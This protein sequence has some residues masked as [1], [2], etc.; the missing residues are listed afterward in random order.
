MSARS[1]AGAVAGVAALAL[2]AAALTLPGAVTADAGRPAGA[3]W[4]AN[5]ED[6]SLTV[7]DAATNEVAATLE[8]VAGPHNVQAGSGTTVWAVASHADTL[9]RLDAHYRLHGELPTGGH[10]AHVVEAPGGDV[11]VTNE[12]DG[13]VSVVDAAALR[14]VAT[15]TVGRAPH[16]LRPSPDGRLVLVANSGSG[17][18]TAIDVRSRRA[19]FELEVG[20]EP[21]QVAFAPGGRTAYVT[22]RGE[23]AVAKI[24]LAAR[25]VVARTSV[26][27]GPAQLHATP[28]GRLLVVTNQGTAGRPGTTVSFVSTAAFRETARVRA[29]LGPHG[30]AV[31]PGGRR[32]YV[33]NLYSHDLSVIDL[34]E[35]RTVATV[36]TGR[37]PNGVTFSAVEPPRLVR[38]LALG[39]G[40]GGHGH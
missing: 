37:S 12:E 16:G 33:T 30:V 15:I 18:V 5:E 23:D 10:P 8:G 35:L 28:D 29:G 39:A 22:L 9:L 34:A 20:A 14:A 2:L 21:V 13:T 27:R 19:L 11:F 7:V 38:P 3:I 1:V 40:R 32:A 26:G 31:D 36:E 6:G 17:T 4:V 24:D 25:K